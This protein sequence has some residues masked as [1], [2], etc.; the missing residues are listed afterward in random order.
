MLTALYDPAST[1]EKET[2]AAS[3]VIEEGGAL[4]GALGRGVGCFSIFKSLVEL[5]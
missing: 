4:L 5:Q 3:M 1:D 2:L